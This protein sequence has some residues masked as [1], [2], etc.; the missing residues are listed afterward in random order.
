MVCTAQCMKSPVPAARKL[1]GEQEAHRVALTGSDPPQGRSE[2]TMQLLADRLVTLGIIET[3]SDE[4]VRRTLK[5]GRQ[6]LATQTMVHPDGECGVRRLHGEC[7]DRRI[8]DGETLAREVAAWQ[9]LRNAAHV[10]VDWRFGVPEARVTFRTPLSHHIS[11]GGGLGGIPARRYGRRGRHVIVQPGQCGGASEAENHCQDV[12]RDAATQ[13]GK[14]EL[15]GRGSVGV[16]G[17]RR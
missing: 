5:R 7:V 9:V 13:M 4:T 12:V 11:C 2:W 8:G 1:G 14:V 10:T 16:P 15:R 6:A 17:R 3:I